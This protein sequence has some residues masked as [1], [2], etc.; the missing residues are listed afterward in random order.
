LINVSPWDVWNWTEPKNPAILPMIIS[1]LT[2]SYATIGYCKTDF[3]FFNLIV[4]LNLCNLYEI[5]IGRIAGFL[6]S[7]QFQIGEVPP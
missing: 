2:L 3:I 6:G 1:C 4:I 5:I 7:V